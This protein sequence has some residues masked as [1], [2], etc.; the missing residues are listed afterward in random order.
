M[1]ELTLERAIELA[2]EAVAEKGA[3]YV[4]TNPLADED[5]VG[6]VCLYAHGD[7]CGCIVG[8][9]YRRH[10]A[11]IDQVRKLD[12]LGAVSAIPNEVFPR[13]EQAD[14]FLRMVQ[15]LQDGGRP[16][17]EAVERAAANWEA[18]YDSDGDE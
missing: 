15:R 5:Y 13:T 12:K 1:E 7:E 16:W 10:G 14:K 9:I 11:S 3:D 2:R 17:G 18:G 4:Y 6:P 8:N